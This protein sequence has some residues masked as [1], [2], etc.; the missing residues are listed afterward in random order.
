[1]TA[2]TYTSDLSDVFLFEG[3]GSVSAYGGGAAGLTAETEF[4]MEGTNA[5]DK[6]VTS[7]AEKGFMYDNTTNFTIGADDHFYIWM[8]SSVF[9]INDTYQNRGI[10]VSIGDDT[11]NFVKFHVDGINTLPFGGGKSYAVRFVNTASTNQRTLVSTPGTTPSWIGG[12]LNVTGNSK[13]VNLG[14]DG[15]RIGWGYTITNGTG[16]DTEADFAGI[17]SDDSST[18]EGVLQ[19]ANGGYN[20][21][22]KLK[23]GSTA[24]ECEFKDSNTNIYILSSFHHLADFAEILIENASSIVTLTNVSFISIPDP[25]PVDGS[26]TTNRG[27]LEVITDTATLTFQNVSFIGTSDTVLGSSS[28][29][30]SCNWI[31]TGRIDLNEADISGSNIITSTVAA[32]EGAIYDNRTTTG[33]TSVSELEGCTISQGTN[34]HH[35]IR[36]GTNVDDNL[37]LTGIEFTGFSSSDDVDGSTLRFDAT[38]GSINVSLV[39]CTVDGNPASDANVGVDAGAG[40]SVTLV[41]SPKTTKVTVE[42]SAGTFIQD[43]RVFLQTSDTGGGSGF[44]YDAA[45]STLTQTGGTA[46]LTASAAHGL[47]TNDYVVV[48]DAGDEYYNKVAQITVTSTTVFT[49]SVDSGASASA[50]GTPVFSYVAV[51]GLTDVNGE[52]QSS[53]TWSASQGLSGWVRKSTTSPYYKETMLSVADASGGTDLLVALQSDE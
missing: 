28:T 26:V 18:S 19:L 38:T 40:F 30:S 10:H 21:T 49:Y 35:A 6:Q 15:A 22:G 12:G 5:V 52:V 50:G 9:G 43:A 42:N 8:Y 11:S 44:P 34:A 37:T 51:Y 27:R 46:T 4:A 20:L 17:E 53:K 41:V 23:I 29:L 47:A 32:D 13:D 45:T 16:A 25:F 14:I 31:G 48:R 24:T 39:D 33:A 3:T 36:F 7:S 2:A 1:M